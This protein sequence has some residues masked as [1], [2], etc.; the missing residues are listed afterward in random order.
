ME[1][2]E[3]EH[4]RKIGDVPFGSPVFDVARL[5]DRQT[6]YELALAHMKNAKEF[7]KPAVEIKQDYPEDQL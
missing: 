7:I 6:G 5:H 2:L 1:M 4:P 3:D